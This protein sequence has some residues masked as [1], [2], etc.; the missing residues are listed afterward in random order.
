[1]K[2]KKR[3]VFR[4]DGEAWCRSV[5]GFDAGAGRNVQAHALMLFIGLEP[6]DV[7]AVVGRK[8]DVGR[9]ERGVTRPEAAGGGPARLKSRVNA[10]S[11]FEPSVVHAELRRLLSRKSASLL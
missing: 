2:T 8:S 6:G 4:W 10:G 7:Q 9:E 5:S 11:G 3:V 1:M